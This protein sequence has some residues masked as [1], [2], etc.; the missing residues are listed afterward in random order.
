MATVRHTF[1][2]SLPDGPDPTLLQ[3]SHWNS[4]HTLDGVVETINGVSP[5]AQGNIDITGSSVATPPDMG[6]YV[7]TVAPLDMITYEAWLVSRTGYWA[8]WQ[9]TTGLDIYASAILSSATADGAIFALGARHAN[10]EVSTASLTTAA[11]TIQALTSTSAVGA[12]GTIA[13]AT[14]I[15]AINVLTSLATAYVTVAIENSVTAAGTIF[16]LEAHE[17]GVVNASVLTY[18]STAA[19]TITALTST[20]GQFAHASGYDSTAA[21]TITALTSTSGVFRQAVVYDATVTGTSYTSVANVNTSDSTAPTITTGGFSVANASS[22]TSTSITSISIAATDAVGVVGWII[23]E[24]AT[25]PAHDA[26]D[27]HTVT[28]TTSF[29][30]SSLTYTASSA[31]V[32]NLYAYVKDAAHNVSTTSSN[33]TAAVTITLPANAWSP[34]LPITQTDEGTT[35]TKI[36]K[37]LTGIDTISVSGSCYSGGEDPV[38]GGRI[39]VSVTASD[40]NYELLAESAQTNTGDIP[41]LYTTIS[42]TGYHYVKLTAY[43][44]QNFSDGSSTTIDECFFE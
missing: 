43:V 42:Y 2:S 39:E 30:S 28:S 25:P 13:N 10:Y 32:T 23:T 24:S 36:L 18:N 14:A 31:S 7:G 21:G 33:T 27:W 12:H 40:S 3:P 16:Y 20:V 19:G 11:G 5:D 1:L 4:S 34:A 22:L 41:G 6:I 35:S 44:G 15:G 37:D 9:I 17:G 26:A 8:F 29:S 38:M